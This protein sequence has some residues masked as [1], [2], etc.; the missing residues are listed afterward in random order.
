MHFCN[1][2]TFKFRWIEILG[3]RQTSVKPLGLL[4]SN[5]RLTMKANPLGEK[6]YWS[7]ILI[8]ISPLDQINI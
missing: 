3:F 6:A 2:V 5:D 7:E 8:L 4:A 1:L